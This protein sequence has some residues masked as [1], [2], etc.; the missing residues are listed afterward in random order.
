VKITGILLVAL[1]C[2]LIVAGCSSPAK[3]IKGIE[4]GMTAGEVL[5]RMGEPYT[6]RAAHFYGD[7]KVAE[8]WEYLSP[9]F[10][11]GE[12]RTFLIIFENGK[13]VRWGLEEDMDLAGSSFGG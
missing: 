7:G 6:I 10:T 12:T 13:L 8:I 5:D 4:L 3:K 9:A 11:F 2:V 1:M